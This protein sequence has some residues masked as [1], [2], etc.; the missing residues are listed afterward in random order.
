MSGVAE[1]VLPLS[2]VWCTVTTIRTIAL[3]E[4][5]ASPAALIAVGI[6][7]FRSEVKGKKRSIFV[8]RALKLVA[9]PAPA[10][11]LAGLQCLPPAPD[12]LPRYIRS[13][14]SMGASHAMP[15]L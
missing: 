2:N 8:A 6:N 10:L 1:R 9:M 7:R 5:A 15:L 12:F 4:Q 13:L 11:L 14:G 3:L